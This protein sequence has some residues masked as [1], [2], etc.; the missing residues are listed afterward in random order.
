M[1]RPPARVFS[2]GVPQRGH[3]SSVRAVDPELVLHSPARICAVAEIRTLAIDPAPQRRADTPSKSRDL[4]RG[5]LAGWAQRMNVRVP[6][7][8]VRVDVPESGNRPLVEDRDLH[9]RAT[10]RE[11]PGEEDGREASTE[12]LRTE[13]Y[14]EMLFELLGLEQQPRPEAAQ[15]AVGDPRPVVELENGS[16]VRRVLVPKAAGH[17]QVDEQHR[18]ALETNQH[19]LS[20]PVDGRNAFPLEP[21]RDPLRILWPRQPL[22]RDPRRRDPASGN[23]R[24]EP[25]ALG[26]DLRK[27]RHVLPDRL[28]DDR[29][30]RGWLVADP[31]RGQHFRRARFGRLLGPRVHLREHLFASDGVAALLPADDPHRMVDAIGLV[32]LPAPRRRA[33]SPTSSAS[34]DTTAPARGARTSAT[35]GARGSTSSS[36]SPPCARIQRL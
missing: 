28:E 13:P 19:V 25:P 21:G 35:T 9:R 12:R 8:L 29:A 31:V 20:A 7:R 6:E 1:P 11:T 23:A 27:L 15:V 3:G 36:G 18:A 30:R 34:S 2:I 14:R 17:P 26:L 10:A 4:V 5:K 24:R 32:R 16:L 22:V 33:A